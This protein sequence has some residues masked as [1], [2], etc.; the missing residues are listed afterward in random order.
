MRTKGA[1]R[2]YRCDV[3]YRHVV[4]EDSNMTDKLLPPSGVLAE[5]LMALRGRLGWSQSELARRMAINGYSWDRTTVAK[6]EKAT[7]Q[8]NVD[9]L[10]A[11]AHVLGL[12]PIALLVP[13]D[14]S[15][16][17]AVTPYAE[18]VGGNLWRWM[19]ATTFRGGNAELSETISVDEAFARRRFAEEACPDHVA[20][21]EDRL[22]GL[23][24]AIHLL[25]GV[26]SLA[27]IDDFDSSKGIA[28]T[29]NQV[30]EL[31]RSM[32]AQVGYKGSA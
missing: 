11:L 16:R 20:A 31:V 2:N 10:V 22:P 7:R 19:T 13:S 25:A 30:A 32:Q 26:Q 4:C 23:R 3:A 14:R 5:R 9:D 28:E 24:K 15:Q 18:E 6:I 29:L 27:G 8:V 12:P 1:E 17:V 21:A